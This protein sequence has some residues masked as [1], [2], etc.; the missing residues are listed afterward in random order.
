MKH[1]GGKERK[2]RSGWPRAKD[3]LPHPAVLTPEGKRRR[4]EWRA[5]ACA[6]PIP[7]NSQRVRAIG[8]QIRM[9]TVTDAESIGEN[10]TKECT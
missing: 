2:Q 8:A 7:T 5:G 1:N 3:A 10:V 4:A 9:N 6:V